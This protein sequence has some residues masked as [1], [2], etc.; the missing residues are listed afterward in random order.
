[1]Q[2]GHLGEGLIPRDLRD[3]PAVDEAFCFKLQNR[4]VLELLVDS[5]TGSKAETMEQVF[6]HRTPAALSIYQ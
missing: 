5:F 4:F 2:G 3:S 6:D 1:M